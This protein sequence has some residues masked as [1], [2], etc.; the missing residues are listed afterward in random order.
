MRKRRAIIIGGVSIVVVIAGFLFVITQLNKPVQGAVSTSTAAV[1]KN[2]Y[3]VSLTPAPYVNRYVSFTYPSGLTQ[4][5]SGPIQ[6]PSVLD[7]TFVARDVTSWVLAIDISTHPSSVA[8][9]ASS[10]TLRKDNP[11][12]YQQSQM[13]VN[14]KPVII[15]TDTTTSGFSRVAYLVHD[16][17]LATVSLIGDDAVGTQPLQETFAMVLH[18]WQWQQ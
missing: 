9:D 17:L 8:T 13:I 5:D 16:G 1:A 7:A 6:P 10:Y 18:S 2:A 3:S 15:M 14:G 4:R 11:A 12:Q